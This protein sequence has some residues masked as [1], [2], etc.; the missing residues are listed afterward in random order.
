MIVEV[1]MGLKYLPELLCNIA[2]LPERGRRDRNNY[3]IGSYVSLQFMFKKIM[4]I[5]SGCLPVEILTNSEH[6]CAIYLHLS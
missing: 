6:F 2:L 4:I 1:C 3:L 5:L